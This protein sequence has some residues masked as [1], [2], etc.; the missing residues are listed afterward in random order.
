MKITILF[1]SLAC[2]CLLSGNL[3]AQPLLYIGAQGGPAVSHVQMAGGTPALAGS[4]RQLGLFLRYGKSPYY[5]LNASWIRAANFLDSEGMN[6]GLLPEELAFHQFGISGVMGVHLVD[7]AAFKFRTSMGPH[8]GFTRIVSTTPLP[9]EPEKQKYLSWLF[10]AGV[11]LY[12]FNLDLNYHFGLSDSIH[13]AGPA[14]ES[15][16]VNMVTLGIGVHI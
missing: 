4:G 12:Y 2:F 15:H 3:A 1:A 10:N 14:A 16:R 11:D 9:A 7:G 6:P 13:L 5:Q 8:L